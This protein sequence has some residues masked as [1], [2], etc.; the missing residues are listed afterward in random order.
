M[1]RAMS[2]IHGF[3]G[4]K[5]SR[6][7]SHMGGRRHL[8]CILRKRRA[9]QV[10]KMDGTNLRTQTGNTEQWKIKQK[11]ITPTNKL[12][13]LTSNFKSS[14]FF[15]ALEVI[16]TNSH[17]RH[18]AICQ[19]RSPVD[20]CESARSVPGLIGCDL[21]KDQSQVLHI[22]RLHT[23]IARFVG[24]KK[25][26]KLSQNRVWQKRIL[27]QWKQ[28]SCHQ[29]SFLIQNSFLCRM[30]KQIWLSISITV[31]VKAFVK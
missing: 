28:R 24:L 10:A 16:T 4:R 13:K 11:I 27:E 17:V 15:V 2:T 1:K 9:L 30:R 18:T 26:K 12:H 21:L 22:I 29:C 14:T 25:I 5:E 23:K 8:F 6:N 3:W 31:M 20:V 7:M 19:P